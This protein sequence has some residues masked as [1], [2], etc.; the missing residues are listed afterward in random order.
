[1]SF[2]CGDAVGPRTWPFR[3]MSDLGPARRCR[4]ELTPEDLGSVPVDEF[5]GLLAR[6]EIPEG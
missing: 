4:S 6:V 5:A 1:M 2:L 3:S